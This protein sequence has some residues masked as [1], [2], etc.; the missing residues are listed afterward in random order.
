[1]RTQGAQ[2]QVH[3]NRRGS[4]DI[5]PKQ[6]TEDDEGAVNTTARFSLRTVRH[7]QMIPIEEELARA[8]ANVGASP[9]ASDHSQ[10]PRRANLLSQSPNVC[11]RLRSRS[12]HQGRLLSHSRARPRPRPRSR[13][14]TPPQRARFI[15]QS[16]PGEPLIETINHLVRAEQLRD[17]TSRETPRFR[18][19]RR[20]SPRGGSGYTSSDMRPPPPPPPRASYTFSSSSSSSSSERRSRTRFNAVESRVRAAEAEKQRTSAALDDVSIQLKEMQQQ[21]MLLEALVSTDDGDCAYVAAPPKHISPRAFAFAASQ[22]AAMLAEHRQRAAAFIL[23]EE[24][25]AA[26]RAYE[27]A[28]ERRIRSVNEQRHREEA[29]EEM[30]AKATLEALLLENCS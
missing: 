2:P 25:D 9:D 6:R 14:R 19:R 13:K 11:S 20:W 17:T 24:G 23:R 15:V 3:I 21:R 4:I 7:L 8:R 5:L 28:E 16:P 18:R 30:R 12:P 10:T 27:Y 26:A 1:M 29:R 22:R